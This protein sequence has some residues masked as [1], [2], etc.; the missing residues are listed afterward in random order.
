MYYLQ[1]E[2]S[3][4]A[5]HFLTGYDGKCRHIHGHRWRVTA[6]VYGEGLQSE[7]S[8][9]G[10]LVDFGTLKRDLKDI[11]DGFDH[12]LI[13]EAGG[14]LQ[15]LL[16]LLVEEGFHIVTVPFRTTAEC[17]A[18]YFFEVLKERGHAVAEVTVYETPTNAATYAE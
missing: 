18:R 4:D 3:F 1:S 14:A 12:A 6:K 17:F 13:V 9:R 16:D 11:T 10:M 15:A 8:E 2:N 5:A 7:G